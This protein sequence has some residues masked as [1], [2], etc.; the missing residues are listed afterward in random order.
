[1]VLVMIIK[2]QKF[3]YTT[4]LELFIGVLFS[5]CVI[6]SFQKIRKE[7]VAGMESLGM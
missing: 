2:N 5:Y 6:V 4:Q 3:D 1:M 7:A